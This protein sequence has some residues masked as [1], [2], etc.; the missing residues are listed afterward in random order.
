MKFGVDLKTDVLM[1]VCFFCAKIEMTK[2]VVKSV[3]KYSCQ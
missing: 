2:K 1:C 3:D